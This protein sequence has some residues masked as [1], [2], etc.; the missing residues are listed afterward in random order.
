MRCNV[1]LLVLFGEQSDA[2]GLPL[3]PPLAAENRRVVIVPG[4]THFIPMEEPELT[5]RMALDF[6][7]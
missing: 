7:G 1:P 6:L 4:T 2:P 3:A 5:A